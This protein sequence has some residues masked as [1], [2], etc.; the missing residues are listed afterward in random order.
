MN[1]R[2]NGP[3]VLQTKDERELFS[4]AIFLSSIVF[5]LS[6]KIFKH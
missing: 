2:K 4:K 6:S 5:R 3:S 1:R